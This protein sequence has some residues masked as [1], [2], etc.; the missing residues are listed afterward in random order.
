MLRPG[1]CLAAI[2]K[3]QI[4]NYSGE[5]EFIQKNTQKLGT[6]GAKRWCFD[7]G[8]DLGCLLVQRLEALESK[9]FKKVV[10]FYEKPF[11]NT[12]TIKNRSSL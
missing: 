6:D 3:S 4:Y 9:D 7:K 10:K 5:K 12:A 2:E 8:N 1:N 11:R